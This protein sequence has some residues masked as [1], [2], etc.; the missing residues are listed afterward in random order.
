MINFTT[1]IVEDV[2]GYEMKK[3]FV[4]KN[5][6]KVPDLG[7]NQVSLTV[8]DTEI[9]TRHS[10][11]FSLFSKIDTSEERIKS[12]SIDWGDGNTDLI[13][14]FFTSY[15]SQLRHNYETAGTKPIIITGTDNKG[16]EFVSST[17]NFESTPSDKVVA[18]QYLIERRQNNRFGHTYKVLNVAKWRDIA[19]LTFIDTINDLNYKYRYRVKLRTL[20]RRGFPIDESQFSNFIMV[21]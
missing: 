18:Q 20:D 6:I 19:D 15:F 11:L 2:V 21:N 10:V 8:V 14:G 4:P 12:L 3:T 5:L 16:N 1:S 13:T 9:T 7:N 17:L